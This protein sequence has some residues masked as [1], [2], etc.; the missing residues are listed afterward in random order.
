MK[1][2]DFKSEGETRIIKKFLFFPLRINNE[3]RWLE[4]V[5]IYQKLELI[6]AGD[7][8]GAYWRLEWRNELFIQE[9]NFN[10]KRYKTTRPK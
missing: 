7:M 10:F 6:D 9:E 2:F 5:K 1:F 8:I 3:T 4:W